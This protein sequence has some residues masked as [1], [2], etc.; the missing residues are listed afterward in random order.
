MT[1][2]ATKKCLGCSYEVHFDHQTNKFPIGDH[3]RGSFNH[4]VPNKTSCE[5]CGAMFPADFDGAIEFCNH[6]NTEHPELALN[7][8]KICGIY[9][10]ELRFPGWALAQHRA[11]M[12]PLLYPLPI[13]PNPPPKVNNPAH[14]LNP[15]HVPNPLLS[16][17]LFRV[18]SSIH[19]LIKVRLV[20]L[21]KVANI[22]QTSN[23]HNLVHLLKLDLLEEVEGLAG[24]TEAANPDFWSRV[25]VE[26]QFMVMYKSKG[27]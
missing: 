8:H 22:I 19:H 6:S 24:P 2:H 20:R 3:V 5:E 25:N 14:P 26:L 17:T 21:R 9:G 16:Q 1:E 13:M 7:E 18:L 27:T 11:T 15:D 10:C 4:R 12:H 23:I